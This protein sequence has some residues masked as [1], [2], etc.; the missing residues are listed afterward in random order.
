MRAKITKFNQED[1]YNTFNSFNII[2]KYTSICSMIFSTMVFS[3]KFD[4]GYETI[5]FSIDDFVVSR[6]I[7]EKTKINFLLPKK[8]N[9]LEPYKYGFPFVLTIPKTEDV[10]FL[11]NGKLYNKK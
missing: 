9:F 8:C 5:F 4:N 6:G 10:E 1:I 7:N 3:N 11:V 2:S